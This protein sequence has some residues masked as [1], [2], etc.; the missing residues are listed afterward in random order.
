[1]S[2]PH[3]SDKLVA[4]DDEPGIP[5]AENAP[6]ADLPA[7]LVVLSLD[8]LLPDPQGEI[9]ILDDAADGVAIATGGRPIAQQGV[10]EPHVTATGIDVAGLAYC[11]FSDGLTLYYP[12]TFRVIVEPDSV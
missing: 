8:D 3:A 6:T 12:S 2:D 4:Q 1:M 5:A 10:A 9:V 11:T 7:D